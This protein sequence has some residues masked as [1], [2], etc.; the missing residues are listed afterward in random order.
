MAAIVTLSHAYERY[1]TGH[2]SFIFFLLA[3]IIFLTL[4]ILHHKLL[5]RFAWIDSIFYIIEGAL[6]FIIA[7]EFFEADKKGLPYLY[8]LAG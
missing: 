2:N 3:G 4:A 7:Q 5:N 6:S 1:E 8:L